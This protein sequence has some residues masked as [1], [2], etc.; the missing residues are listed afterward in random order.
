MRANCIH[1]DLA[2]L[3]YKMFSCDPLGAAIERIK[4][5]HIRMKFA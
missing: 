3:I 2:I 5:L 1:N 4:V